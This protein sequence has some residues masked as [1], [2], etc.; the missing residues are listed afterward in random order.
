MIWVLQLMFDVRPIHLLRNVR[1]LQLLGIEVIYLSFFYSILA[2]GVYFRDKFRAGSTFRRYLLSFVYIC[3][4]YKEMCKD[5]N[6]SIKA[7]NHKNF[8]FLKSRAV[9]MFVW[10]SL[11]E[12]LES[13]FLSCFSITSF[14]LLFF[15]FMVDKR[16][17]R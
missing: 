11:V 8:L 9:S 5:C 13:I 3:E 16:V 1:Q 6:L 4:V 10:Y 14:L 15:L 12:N 17:R 7:I 2:V